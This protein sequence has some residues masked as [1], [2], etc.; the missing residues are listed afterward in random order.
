M[1][2]QQKVE[3]FPDGIVEV[4]AENG[5]RL[6]EKKATLRFEKQTVGVNRY[7]RARESISSSEIDRVI[8]VPHTSLVD[9]MDIVLVKTEDDRQYRILR[10][11]EKPEKG[12]DLWELKSVQVSIKRSESGNGG[13][14]ES[15][16][17]GTESGDHGD[18]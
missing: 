10:I 15:Q 7:Y 8:K 3:T 1:R 13:T 16:N 2:P 5:R 9:R 18:P 17:S 4:Y 12:V 14:Q 11:Q 6:G